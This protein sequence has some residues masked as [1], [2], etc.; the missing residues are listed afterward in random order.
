VLAADEHADRPAPA[1][2]IELT[3]AEIRRLFITLI[4]EPA[5][6]LV[7]PMRVTLAMTSPTPCPHQPLPAPTGSRTMAITIYGWS[8]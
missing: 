7:C 4:V 3:Y 1:G 6:T 5:R 8:T 2:L